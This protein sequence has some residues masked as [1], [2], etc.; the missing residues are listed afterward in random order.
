MKRVIFSITNFIFSLTKSNVIFS[1]PLGKTQSETSN[2]AEY[3][4]FYSY[5]PTNQ[6]KQSDPNTL[7]TDEQHL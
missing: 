2:S 3:Y 1:T 5:H 6:N 7:Y 4:L